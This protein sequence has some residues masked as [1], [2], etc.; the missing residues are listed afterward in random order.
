MDGGSLW[1]ASGRFRAARSSDPLDDIDRCVLLLA[2]GLG[3]NEDPFSE[4]NFHVAL[5]HED[6]LALA[7]PGLVRGAVGVTERV[8]ELNKFLDID[9]RLP[10]THWPDAGAPPDLIQL[11][12]RFPDGGLRAI[13]PQWEAYDDEVADWLAFPGTSRLVVAEAGWRRLEEV[14]S[15]EFRPPPSLSPMLEPLLA[16]ELYDTAVREV[17]V[18]LES[19]MR[20]SSHGSQ[21][22][23]QRLVDAY[24]ENLHTRRVLPSAQLKVLRGELR[25]AFRFVRNEFAHNVVSLPR[26]RA[27]SLL[28]RMGELYEVVVDLAAESS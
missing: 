10:L 22:Y 20:R 4:E 21:R 27:L 12:A 8:H 26:S 11:Y 2:E 18:H 13:N 24:I 14:L 5:W 28:Q 17:S 7:S 3:R 6:V 16:A 19:E 25:T 1:G 23:G 9:S 15:R